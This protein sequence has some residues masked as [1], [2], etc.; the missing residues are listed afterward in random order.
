MKGREKTSKGRKGK[1]EDRRSARLRF[2]S[3]VD[4]RIGVI[5]TQYN[6]PL[7]QDGPKVIDVGSAVV[8]IPGV[9]CTVTHGQFSIY[10]SQSSEH[11]LPIRRRDGSTWALFGTSRIEGRKKHNPS[12]VSHQRLLVVVFLPVF[13][14]RMCC[15][16]CSDVRILQRVCVCVFGLLPPSLLGCAGTDSILWRGPSRHAAAS[17]GRGQRG[18][19]EETRSRFHQGRKGVHRGNRGQ[20]GNE[21][22][23]RGIKMYVDT[24]RRA[25]VAKHKDSCSDG[26][27]AR[28]GKHVTVGLS[29]G[30]RSFSLRGSWSQEL[31]KEVSQGVSYENSLE[32]SP[33]H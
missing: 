24:H 5:Y 31:Y 33:A 10:V 11:V 23:P 25:R 16:C 18:R 7:A 15:M 1:G 14:C 8:I 21:V 27:P 22:R 4:K 32:I 30:L 2:R 28:I 12:P 13:G 19:S 17:M 9:V 26:N 3:G 20:N 29:F 6:T